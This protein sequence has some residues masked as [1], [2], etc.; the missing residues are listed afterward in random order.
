ML[1][2]LSNKIGWKDLL[3]NGYSMAT[4]DLTKRKHNGFF[5]LWLPHG[6]GGLIGGRLDNDRPYQ[7]LT[8][9]V[10][11]SDPLLHNMMAI[12]LKCVP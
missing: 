10:A 1:T 6:N 4:T 7:D 8:Y 2:I 11:K 12:G 5:G 3:K 9:R